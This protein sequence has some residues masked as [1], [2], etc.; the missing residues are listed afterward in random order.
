MRK[1]LVIGLATFAIGIFL[2]GIGGGVAFEEY[3]SFEYGGIKYPEGTKEFTYEKTFSLDNKKTYQADTYFCDAKC[4]IVEDDS[5]A[6]DEILLRVKYNSMLDKE[7]YS[8]EMSSEEIEIDD[9]LRTVLSFYRTYDN[10]SSDFERFMKAKDQIL[11]DLKE[12]KLCEYRYY[13][14][15]ES[16][17]ILVNPKAKFNIEL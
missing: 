17:E 7:N 16:V 9:E 3:S 11:K 10:S 12:H 15:V 8:V 5:V 1:G 2:M 14:E 4:S 13:D 6:K